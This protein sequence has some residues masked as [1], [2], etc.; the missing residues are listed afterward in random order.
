MSSFPSDKTYAPTLISVPS[1]WAVDGFGSRDLL[2]LLDFGEHRLIRVRLK[3]V[4]PV[5]QLV[6][7]VGELEESVRLVPFEAIPV[8]FHDFDQATSSAE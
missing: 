7:G 3:E 6:G 1:V 2:S 4:V 8:S 5:E